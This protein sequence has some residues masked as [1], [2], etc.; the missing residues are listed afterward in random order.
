MKLSLILALLVAGASFAAPEVTP[1]LAAHLEEVSAGE[2]V[3]V[4]IVM[5][6]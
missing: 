6:E 5:E 4:M 3:R 2:L 1:R